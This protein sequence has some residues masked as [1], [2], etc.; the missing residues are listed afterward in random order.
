MHLLVR[1]VHV[2]GLP[3]A[4]VARV[5]Q[6]AEEGPEL[7]RL[8]V[9][10][11]PRAVEGLAGRL[12]PGE[13]VRVGRDGRVVVLAQ[14]AR[15]DE[16]VKVREALGQRVAQQADHDHGAA[17]QRVHDGVLLGRAKPLQAARLPDP[18]VRRQVREGHDR[19]VALRDLGRMLRERREVEVLARLR[20]GHEPLGRHAHQH[21][22]DGRARRLGRVHEVVQRL[23]ARD[24]DRVAL[25]LG[26]LVSVRLPARRA[27][28]RPNRQDWVT[29]SVHRGPRTA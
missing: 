6:Q 28:L 4:V 19:V 5:E 27:L 18:K 13:H 17:R 9:V 24:E 16:V 25:L 12:R 23:L 3:S 8:G 1:L 11:A 7:E 15:P 14:V 26:E 22:G 29:E 21:L 20:A 2:G 10:A